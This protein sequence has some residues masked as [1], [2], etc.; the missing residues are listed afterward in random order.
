MYLKDIDVIKKESELDKKESKRLEKLKPNAWKLHLQKFRK[1][2]PNIT[3]K[4]VM[5]EAKKTY[6][7]SSLTGSTSKS[8]SKPS[9]KKEIIKKDDLS[10]LPPPPDKFF[11]E[12]YIELLKKE[13]K[14]L[15]KNN[16]SE[17]LEDIKASYNKFNKDFTFIANSDMTKKDKENAMSDVFNKAI[18]YNQFVFDEYEESMD[19]KSWN[20]QTEDFI[21]LQEN[22]YMVLNVLVDGLPPQ[23]ITLEDYGENTKVEQIIEE[24]LRAPKSVLDNYTEI[25]EKIEDE[26]DEQDVTSG[27]K[28]D[29]KDLLPEELQVKN[30]KV[31]N[32]DS[33]IYLETPKLQNNASIYPQNQN[34]DIQKPTIENFPVVNVAKKKK[35]IKKS[36]EELQANKECKNIES[37]NAKDNLNLGLRVYNYYL[38]VTRE[39]NPKI[40]RKHIDE[41]WN[42]NK[43]F[44][45]DHIA[46]ILIE[47]VEFCGGNIYDIKQ[48]VDSFD[49]L[50]YIADAV[51]GGNC[52]ADEYKSGDKCYKKQKRPEV[53]DRKV[54]DLKNNPTNSPVRRIPQDPV[55]PYVRFVEPVSRKKEKQPFIYDFL[56]LRQDDRERSLSN[57]QDWLDDLKD[58]GVGTYTAVKKILELFNPF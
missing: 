11:D 17:L 21:N 20:E 51:R 57:P 1:E 56:G 3:G 39:L 10:K 52:G 53:F 18:T 33:E 31:I 43:E 50:T 48:L 9:K 47:D 44:V 41:M 37:K 22:Y 36:Q 38:K 5:K 26:N 2:N 4:D 35:I 27:L 28:N 6:K 42:E 12:D 34:L 45:K 55:K 7:K 13:E 8:T 29:E 19:T 49:Y 46:D 14:K 23:I 30:I 24:S 25:R 40:S 54:F 58:I 15:E 32:E 16:S